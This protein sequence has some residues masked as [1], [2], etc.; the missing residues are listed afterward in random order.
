TDRALPLPIREDSAGLVDDRRE[1]DAVPI[2]EHRIDHRLR[3]TR[4]DE[5]VAI[6]VP[7][8]ANEPRLRGDLLPHRLRSRELEAFLA[9]REHAGIGEAID[10]RNARAPRVPPAAFASRRDDELSER[11]KAG[12]AD[13]GLARRILE[14]D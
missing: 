7:P 11:G 4:G 2:G 6:R 13:D 10:A 1:R 8:A 3:A 12:G 9:S 5:E 14:P